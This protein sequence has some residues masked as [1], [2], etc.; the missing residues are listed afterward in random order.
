MRSARIRAAR[1]LTV[2][3]VLLLLWTTGCEDPT[4]AVTGIT[5]VSSVAAPNDHFHRATIPLS[6]VDDPP[7]SGRNYVS[8][9]AEG[10][11]HVVHVSQAQLIILQQNNAVVTVTCAANTVTPP[12]SH[13]HQFTFER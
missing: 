12:A 9:T 10:H 4:G 11:S 3:A 2:A 6:D 8:T 7:A 13:T 5:A 1:V